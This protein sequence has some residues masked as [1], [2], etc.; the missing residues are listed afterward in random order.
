MVLE[1]FFHKNFT[2]L[3]KLFLLVLF[4]DDKQAAK[5]DHFFIVFRSQFFVF[6]KPLSVFG[7]SAVRE[8]VDGLS[9]VFR[10]GETL[11]S[12]HELSRLNVAF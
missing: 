8:L 6:G 9:D 12:G 10:E 4:I 5:G 2:H 7:Y 3:S 1:I 11:L